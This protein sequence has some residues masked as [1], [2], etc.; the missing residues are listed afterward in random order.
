M[1]LTTVIKEYFTRQHLSRICLQWKDSISEGLKSILPKTK[2]RVVHLE[3]LNQS[4]LPRW[5]IQCFTPFQMT[6]ERC[7][8]EKLRFFMDITYKCYHKIN[9]IN[10]KDYSFQYLPSKHKRFRKETLW[11]V[12]TLA[13][14]LPSCFMHE[15]TSSNVFTGD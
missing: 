10:K 4:N 13:S 3:V 9:Q 1:K 11:T 14:S 7:S 2:V 15:S 12:T 6:K 5:I 8:I